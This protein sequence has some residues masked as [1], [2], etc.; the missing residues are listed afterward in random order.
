M[1]IDKMTGAFKTQVSCVL[2]VRPESPLTNPTF[3]RLFL[4][5]ILFNFAISLILFVLLQNVLALNMKKCAFIAP[6]SWHF[7]T[8][9]EVSF[10]HLF[11]S[12]FVLILLLS[13]SCIVCKQ[14]QSHVAS[15]LMMLTFYACEQYSV[16]IKA[17]VN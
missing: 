1:C 5:T 7:K 10:F 15:T 2:L 14:T 9:K 16:A 8:K 12:P 6:S 17:L 13:F 3:L 4:F 11:H